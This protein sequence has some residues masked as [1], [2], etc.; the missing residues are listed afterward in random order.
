[1]TKFLSYF[2]NNTCIIH[3]KMQA[4][5]HIYMF[6]QTA[7]C[8]QEVLFIDWD[9]FWN[10][11][12]SISIMFDDVP[13]RYFIGNET[14]LK[15]D[16]IHVSE[17]VEHVWSWFDH[18]S[19]GN[20]IWSVHGHGYHCQRILA[21]MTKTWSNMSDYDFMVIVS[22]GHSSGQSHCFCTSASNYASA[23]WRLVLHI[24][25]TC[26]PHVNKSWVT[27]A[28]CGIRCGWSH[29]PITIQHVRAKW[30]SVLSWRACSA[31]SEKTARVSRSFGNFL[32]GLKKI[33]ANFDHWLKHM[34]CWCVISLRWYRIMAVH[35]CC[36]FRLKRKNL[37]S[38]TPW[39][40]LSVVGLEEYSAHD[41]RAATL[42][43]GAPVTWR[44]W[45]LW[46]G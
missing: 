25:V 2:F 8:R 43:Q 19:F 17:S 23:Q 31:G 21:N 35:K 15:H 18:V 44:R 24:L 26:S 5:L 12:L 39:C 9:K 20:E 30:G 46:P 40:L 27:R 6:K 33:F 32:N 1:M 3:V 7:G 4:N 37:L 41:W 42:V 45:G 11:P 38:P 22:P 28:L 13:A 10:I 36:T 14:W 34:T 16:L 29:W